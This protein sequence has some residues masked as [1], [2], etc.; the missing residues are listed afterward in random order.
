MADVIREYKAVTEHRE[1]IV[2][3]VLVGVYAIV[4][5][6]VNAINVPNNVFWCDEAFS[7]NLSVMSVK[8][9]LVATAAD[10][11]PPLYYF[12][13]MGATRIFGTSGYVYRIVSLIPLA[14]MM[15]FSM[16]LL[17][18]RFGK[19]VSIVFITLISLL[20]NAYIKNTEV[21]MYSWAFMFVL[22]TFW[23]TFLLIEKETTFRYVLLGIFGLLAAYSHYYALISVVPFF[24]IVMCVTIL[25]KRHMGGYCSHGA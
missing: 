15:L 5:F 24:V 21:R 10:V 25:K 7:A 18:K 2:W 22:A 3:R 14:L 20:P 9:M 19:E 6:A 13:I 12:L 8:E 17:W 4:L 23:I 1:N 11:H 16:S